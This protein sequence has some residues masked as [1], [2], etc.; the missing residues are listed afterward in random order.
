MTTHDVISPSSYRRLDGLAKRHVACPDCGAGK[1]DFC[2]G[3]QSDGTAEKTA[4]VHPGRIDKFVGMMPH[5]LD[6]AAERSV[7]VDELKVE[8]RRRERQIRLLR[9]HARDAGRSADVSPIG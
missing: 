2:I 1:G 9:S 5:F 6:L 7:E 8:Q 4:N 3:R